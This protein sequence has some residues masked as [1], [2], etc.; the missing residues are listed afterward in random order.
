MK[1]LYTTLLLIILA[2]TINAQNNNSL[3]SAE[4]I[5]GIPV[6]VY[7]TPT[8]EFEVLGKAVSAKN[9]LM[10]TANETATV[11]EKATKL[12]NE[13]LKRKKEGKNPEFDAVI[14][15]PARDKMRIIK[16]KEKTSTEA[17]VENMD[18]IPFFL[19]SKPVNDYET[20]TTLP[21]DMSLFA[22]RGM[23]SDKIQ[24]IMNRVLKKKEKGEVKDFDAVIISPDDL[25]LTLIK[26]IN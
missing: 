8:A 11:R 10:I 6:F 3:A 9:I 12:V 23:L 18:G 2:F 4:S 22:K 1:N 15:D 14:I 24:S 25:S 19:F 7:A 13:A 20:V 26:F 17:K 21:A 16:F 5:S